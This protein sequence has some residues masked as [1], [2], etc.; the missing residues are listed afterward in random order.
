MAE[1]TTTLVDSAILSGTVN[2][3]TGDRVVCVV[4]RMKKKQKQAR[5]VS[6]A[7]KKVAGIAYT[8]PIFI[9]A[10][11]GA[12]KRLVLRVSLLDANSKVLGIITKSL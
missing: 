9:P 1:V 6:A 11:P 8:C 3:A 2:A 12:N 5:T 4:Q 7:S 10:P